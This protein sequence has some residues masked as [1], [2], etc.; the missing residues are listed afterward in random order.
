[1]EVSEILEIKEQVESRSKEVVDLVAR[2]VAAGYSV[3]PGEVAT[4]IYIFKNV[5]E[6][7]GNPPKP[8]E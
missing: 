6:A 3:T 4:E 2:L 1:M 8:K 5:L 7:Y